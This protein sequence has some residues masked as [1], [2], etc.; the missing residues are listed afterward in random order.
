[1]CKQCELVRTLFIFKPGTNNYCI[2]IRT[3]KTKRTNKCEYPNLPQCY[4]IR[5]FSTLLTTECCNLLTAFNPLIERGIE[6]KKKSRRKEEEGN[7]VYCHA[8]VK[9]QSGYKR[10]ESRMHL[11]A[12]KTQI[13]FHNA[14]NIIYLSICKA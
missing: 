3:I 12:N 10:T 9:L 2:R 8:V 1:M 11:S 14:R 7:S 13:N 5:T 4:I 6:R